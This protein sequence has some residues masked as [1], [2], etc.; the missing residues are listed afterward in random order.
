MQ[1]EPNVDR[2]A[3]VHI[4]ERAYAF[5]IRGLRFMPTGWLA[6]C[7]TVTC[8]DGTRYFLK[9]H[10][11]D[12][13]AAF[14][15][16]SRAFYLPLTY[17]LHHKGILPWIPAPI[18]NGSR[19][20][21]T[22]WPP[23]V[24]ELAQFVEGTLVGHEGMDGEILARLAGLVGT[25]HRSTS[26]I[27]VD[28]PLLDNFE[29]RFE[30][31]LVRALDEGPCFADHPR[32]GMQ[33][34]S[35]FLRAEGDR[36]RGYLARLQALQVVGR[37]M[38]KARVVCHTDLHGENLMIDREGHLVLCDWEGAMIAPPEH[39]LMFFAGEETFWAAF[40]PH[41]EAAFDPVL[42]H[43]SGMPDLHPAVFEFYYLRR[44][45]EDLADWIIRIREGRDSPEQDREDLAEMRD[46]LAGMAWIPAT[47]R[48]IAQR[49]KSRTED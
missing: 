42:G 30:P 45:L 15:A 7:Y 31:N 19:A 2:T 46:C 13:P 38:D 17:Q 23:Y 12:R 33:A 48:T 34:L 22:A 10:P 39:D 28:E 3:L 47:V 49:L 40:L 24:I 44:G 11:E 26:Q 1:T 21:A 6:A 27:A 14:A 18:P 9:L 16:S 35:A 4:L 36:I 41:Y 20:L 25:L 43:G 5:R 29:I 32:P 37:R 8:E